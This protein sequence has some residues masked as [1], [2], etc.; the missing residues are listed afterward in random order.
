MPHASD[1]K[2]D[3]AHKS[4][5]MLSGAALEAQGMS[6]EHED[7]RSARG[8]FSRCGGFQ[9]VRAACPTRAGWENPRSS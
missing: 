2:P 7:C 6:I 1:R 5:E 3:D 4:V 9:I 8:G